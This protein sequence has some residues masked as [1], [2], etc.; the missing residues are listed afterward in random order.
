MTLRQFAFRNVIR[1]RRVYAAFFMASVSS[2]MVFFIYSMLMFHPRVENEFVTEIAFRGMLIAEVILVLFMLFFLFYSMRA[3]LE[4]RSKEFGIL[5]QLGMEKKQLNKLVLFEILIIGLTS[6]ILGILFGFVFSKFFFMIVREILEITSLSLYFSWKPF[7]LTIGTFTTLFIVISYVSIFTIKDD[8]IIKLIKGYQKSQQDVKFSWFRA[9]FGIVLLLI[10]YFAS[11]NATKTNLIT[12]VGVLPPI[13]T[14]G[15]YLFFTDSVQIFLKLIK[16]NKNIYWHKYRLLSVS[17]ISSMLKSNARMFFISSM[18]SVLAFMAIGTLSSLST[19]SHKYHQLNPLSLVYTSSSQNPYERQ[20]ITQLQEELQDAGLSYRLDRIV[21]KR[22]TSTNTEATVRIIS[23]R[24]LN[25]LAMS[26]GYPLISLKR[27]EAMF[28]AYSEESLRKLSKEK[29]DTVLKESNVKLSIDRTYPKIV[30]AA[31]KLG[32]NQ[33]IVDDDDFTHIYA[34]MQG[35][36]GAA[37]SSHLYIFNVP[38]W[39]ETKYIGH[40]LD[41]IMNAAY[42]TDNE[43]SLPFYFEN[44]GLDYSF[45]RSTFALLLFIGLLAAAVFFLAAGSFIYFKLY[46]NLDEE[47]KQYST[48]HRMGVTK[49]ELRKLVNRQL[50]PQFFLPWGIAMLNSTFAFLS[51]QV[52]WRGI[53]DLSIMREI[54]FVMIALTVA[55]LLYFYLIRWRYLAHLKI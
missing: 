48:L 5:I 15:T 22:Q 50:I 42:A 14:L 49:K 43:R 40:N 16:R 2:V 33:I 25:N 45:I 18:V 38:K 7:A 54:I 36:A 34:P 46:T 41:A 11:A 8:N 3:F 17:E 39:Q 26:L 1:N 24:D 55:Q 6:I 12:L 32:T 44:T 27:G 10:A 51:L 21:V 35:M 20:H 23:E 30:F 29:V 13:V 37:S 4:A 28:L 9:I 19:F 52:F 31:D 47:K 53:A